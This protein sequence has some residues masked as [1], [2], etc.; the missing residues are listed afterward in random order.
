[1]PKPQPTLHLQKYIHMPIAST[2]AQGK[3]ALQ[4]ECAQEENQNHPVY[5]LKDGVRV[6]R[7]L[8]FRENLTARVE[9]FNTLKDTHGKK[10]TLQDR[11]R[12]FDTYLDSCTSV[13]YKARSTIFTIIPQDT[14]LITL[15]STFTQ[16]YLQAEYPSHAVNLDST[17][18]KYNCDLTEGQVLDHNAWLMAVEGDRVLLQEVAN[19]T[20]TELEQHHRKESGMRFY[21]QNNNNPQVDLR[22]ALFVYNLD[23][24]SNA[25]GSS[26]LY[27]DGSFLRVA[28]L[29][30]SAKKR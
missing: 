7:P 1:M 26:S 9:D 10:R 21:V 16:S 23:V 25:D 17:E 29:S 24:S 18:G 4:S 27:G 5:V 11:L 15:P 28:P 6:Y 13:A 3:A 12:L 14:E 19:I 30:S 2:Y 20:F 8:T 22:K